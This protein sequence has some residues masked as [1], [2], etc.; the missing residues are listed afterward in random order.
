VGGAEVKIIDISPLVSERIAN[1]PGDVPY[2]REVALEIGSG[3]NIDLSA[4][5]T[6][7]HVGAHTDAPN[8][9]VAGGAGIDR[10]PLER[11]LGPCQVIRID[12]GRD[13]RMF[14][15]HVREPI[16]APR[17]LFHTGTFPNPEHFNED[18]AALSAPLIDFLAPRGV[19]LVGIDTPSIDPRHDKVLE[20][21]QAV[22]RHDLSILE[23]IVLDHVEPGLYTLVALPLRLEGADASP[24]RAV[25][26]DQAIG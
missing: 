24:V 18:F 5:R 15:Q 19:V 20:A 10:R 23:G 12:I 8:H 25:L 26:L 6:S 7:V 14:P 21:H 13:E 9:Y 17:V 3:D 4:I 11:Y 1:Y 22:A 16:R 2:T